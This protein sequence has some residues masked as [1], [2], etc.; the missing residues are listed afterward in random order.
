M[1]QLSC[2]YAEKLK[3]RQK[4]NISISGILQKDCWRYAI[5]GFFAT[6]GSLVLT[7][8]NGILYPRIEM[9]NNS[10]VILNQIKE[11]LIARGLTVNVYRTLKIN[12]FSEEKEKYTAYRLQ[13]NGYGNLLKFKDVIGFINPKHEEKFRSYI[14]SR[15]G[16]GVRALH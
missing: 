8:N 9:Q 6:D 7:D 13:S 16:S 5:A 12:Y 4:R 1:S 15:C 11:F 14:K 10:F 3:C 2:E